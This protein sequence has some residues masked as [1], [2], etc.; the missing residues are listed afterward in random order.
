MLGGILALIAAVT[1][2][3]NN[4]AFRRG[5][6]TGTVAQA[7]AISLACSGWQCSLS[8]HCSRAPGARCRLSR[9]P[10]MMLC[11]AGILHFAWGRYCNFRATKAM[12]A[13]LVGPAQQSSI[14]VTL[15]P[16]DLLPGE[17]LTPLR[18]AR[19]PAGRPW[20]PRCRCAWQR[21]ATLA[22]RPR[23]RFQPNY[24]EGY[25]FALPV[26]D[27]LWLQPDPG[28]AEPAGWRPARQHR[29]R[30]DRLCRGDGASWLSPC[31][32]PDASRRHAQ[33]RSRVGKWFS[34]SGALVAP[35]RCSATWRWR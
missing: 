20:R 24:A 28:A 10:S 9:D 13:N 1:F 19:H 3:M 2:A 31:C 26:G 7:M 32:R 22:R 35:R 29:R 27:R 5:A 23:Q 25:T 21:K 18:A 30:P 6:L 8:R 33:R 14:V 4:A 16:G 15:A 12:G 17:A 34:I 11:A